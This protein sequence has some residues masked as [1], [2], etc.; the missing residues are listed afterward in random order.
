M[1]KLPAWFRQIEATI[2][3]A[4]LLLI[5]LTISQI[6]ALVIDPTSL[7][8]AAESHA[9]L[10]A[11]SN[12][13]KSKLQSL[14][15]PENDVRLMQEVLIT[16]FRVSSKNIAVLVNQEAT[17]TAIERAFAGLAQRAHRGDFIYIH[18]SGHGSTA[19]DPS[20]ARGEDQ[21]W[22][23]YGARSGQQAG[24][25]DFD[26]LDKEIAVWMKPIY[27]QTDNVV[28]V[29]D[30]CHSAT[31]SRGER[32]GSRAVV[33]DPRKHPLLSELSRIPRP[34]IGVRIGAARDIE[35]AVELDPDKGGICSDKKRC[36]GVFTWYWAQ[37]LHQ[38]QPGERWAD[39][40]NRSFTRVVNEAGVSQR[41]QME[42]VSE[43]AIFGGAFHRLPATLSVTE[44]KWDG[45]VHLSAGTLSG[46][47]K[48]STYRRFDPDRVESPD[49]GTLEVVT[50]EPFY[51]VAQVTK[52]KLNIGDA[53]EETLHVYS[54]E[55]IR[56]YI[57]G[58]FTSSI[59]ADLAQKVRQSLKGLAGFNVVDEPPK[60]NWWVYIV[61]SKMPVSNIS[62]GSVRRLPGEDSP[63]DATQPPVAWVV[64]PQGVLAHDL[65]RTPL[66]DSD[67]GIKNLKA[68]LTQLAW[69]REIK[70]L[71]GRGN[72]SSVALM[73]WVNPQGS[74]ELARGPFPF[75]EIQ[76]PPRFS[77]K[78]S[79]RL[80]NKD[81][82]RSMYAYVFA[83]TPSAAVKRLH[84]RHIDNE[85]E[86]R[87]KKGESVDVDGK[88]NLNEEGDETILLVTTE[89]PL[90]PRIIESQGYQG[91]EKGSRPKSQLELRLAGA[92]RRRGDIETNPDQWG[93]ISVEYPI[94]KPAVN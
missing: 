80:T 22:V 26:I 52:G 44:V 79:F 32:L 74:E 62:E 56:I 40:F 84:P 85:D 27:D 6:A 14:Q 67:T 33:P 64:S 8:Y 29:S 63:P 38:A 69:S 65:M 70:G 9:L 76:P 16:R 53:V 42:G 23:S 71:A 12:Y 7:V 81:N 28:F 78:L 43:R 51:S 18:Y 91:G 88:Y 24:K 17:H 11:V 82:T 48:N 13:E 50:V 47:T 57:G 39:V 3:L 58:D 2:K 75:T 55:P 20:E 5:I 34:E 60:A 25:D 93:V 36:A 19:P 49:L 4:I 68:N 83:V 73:A 21:T 89:K 31:V 90:N 77:D 15:G 1:E 87:L 94:S 92:S 72:T 86:A 59:D 10:I 54:F 46:V 35:S 37:A 41:P 45:S 61:R 30:S 66:S